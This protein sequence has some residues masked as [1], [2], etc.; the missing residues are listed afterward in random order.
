MI[1]K[2]TYFYLAAALII[3]LGG[4]SSCT[5]NFKTINTPWQG[6]PT[7]SVSQLYIAFVSNMNSCRLPKAKR[8]KGRKGGRKEILRVFGCGRL[9][10]CYRRV[11]LGWQ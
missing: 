1:D 8:G 3:L 10:S 11:A 4:A 6:S 2:R 7:A 5:K 9:M